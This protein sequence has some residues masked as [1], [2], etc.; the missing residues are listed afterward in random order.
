MPIRPEENSYLLDVSSHTFRQLKLI[1]PGGFIAYY[2]GTLQEFWTIIQSG[3]G[4]ARST[5]LAALLSG[6]TTIGLF[7]FVLLTPWLRGVEPDFRVWRKSGILSSV[8]PLLTTSIVLGWLLLVMSLAHFSNSGIF[9]GVVGASSVYAL[10]FGLLGLLPAPKV[11][12][13]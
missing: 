5:A 2:F 10:S 6:C 4:L 13:S 9:R 11:K 8:I 1:V 3:A 12:R 7:V